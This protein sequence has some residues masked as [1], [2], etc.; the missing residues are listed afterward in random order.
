MTPGS[1]SPAGLALDS[2][3]GVVA[4]VEPTLTPTTIVAGCVAIVVLLAASAFF[5]GSEIAIF[6]LERHQLSVLLEADDDVDPR[7]HVLQR[8]RENPHRLLVTIL[9]GNNMVNIAMASIASVL[10]AV[11]LSP[12]AAVVVTTFGVSALVLVFGE[13]TPKSYGVAHAERVALRV[14]GPLT[15]VERLLFPLVVFFDAVSRALN[16]VTGGGQD[17]ERPYVTREEIEAL[18]KTGERVGAIEETEHEM[19][20]GVFDLSTTTAREVMVPRVNLIAVDVETPLDEL[21]EVCATNRLTRVPVYQGTLDN[22]VGIADIRDAERALREG[23][24]LSDVLLPTLQV[25][26]GREIDDLLAEM[27]AERVTMV[28]VRDEFGETEGILTVEDILEEIVGE[29]FEVGE[30]RFIRPTTDGLLVKGEVTVGEVNDALG[31]DLT[32]EGEF[33]T[34]AGLI[35]AELGRIGDVGDRIVVNDVALAVDR[36]DGHRI[37]RV[38]VEPLTEDADVDHDEA[39]DEA[40][41]ATPDADADDAESTAD[42]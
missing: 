14:A 22:V 5:S 29:I 6:S 26:E 11:T 20:E 7:A 2:L 16:R 21:I 36:V 19:V 13:I 8:L 18:L 9:V 41:D 28:I 4:Q 34:V 1:I 30:E 37:R 42:R 3:A 27:Q 17:I 23:Q 40:D 10:L 35:N 24:G 32:T 38:R 33:E 12:E 31:V 15:T 25:P 39:S